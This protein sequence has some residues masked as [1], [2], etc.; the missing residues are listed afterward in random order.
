MVGT[1]GCR[2]LVAERQSAT[3]GSGDRSSK[4]L[5]GRQGKLISY[6]SSRF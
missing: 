5:G 2:E 6:M 4:D 3:D 1:S